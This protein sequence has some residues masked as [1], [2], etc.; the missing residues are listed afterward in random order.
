MWFVNW[1]WDSSLPSLQHFIYNIFDIVFVIILTLHILLLNMF[2]LFFYIWGLYEVLLVRLLNFVFQ[3]RLPSN[4]IFIEIKIV[5]LIIVHLFIKFILFYYFWIF[6]W[7]NKFWT[8]RRLDVPNNIKWIESYFL[9]C[10]NFLKVCIAK[11]RLWLI[12]SQCILMNVRKRCLNPF[13]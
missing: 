13:I 2:D 1:S 10:L 11:V 9:L 4:F 7:F 3:W 5:T 8:V 6:P 12:F